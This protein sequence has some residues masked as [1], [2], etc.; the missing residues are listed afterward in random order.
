MEVYV[1]CR[2]AEKI[3]QFIVITG[4]D[5]TLWYYN[6]LISV[7]DLI[8]H[9][10]RNLLYIIMKYHYSDISW[11]GEFRQS[12]LNKYVVQNV[13][14]FFSSSLLFLWVPFID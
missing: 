12:E 7:Q 1:H 11:N 6:I 10:K 9:C 4:G 14:T 13:T 3:R 5:I 2:Q 8:P